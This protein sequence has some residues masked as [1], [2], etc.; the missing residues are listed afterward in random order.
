MK[1]LMLDDTG[2]LSSMRVMAFIALTVAGLLALLPMIGVGKCDA[3][4]TTILWFLMAAF[5]GKGLQ[6]FAEAKK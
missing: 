1:T 5:G 2:N 3:D 4:P 6:K